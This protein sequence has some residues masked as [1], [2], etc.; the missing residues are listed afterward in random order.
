MRA[1]LNEKQD[2]ADC[3]NPD[4][5][6]Y[7]WKAL[8]PHFSD[9][10]PDEVDCNKCRAYQKT[11]LNLENGAINR[12]LRTLRASLAW[13]LGI[14]ENPGVF[15]FLQED[16]P[17]DRFLSKDEFKRLLDRAHSP[18]LKLILHLAIATAARKGALLELTW[19]QIR[20]DQ[21]ATFLGKNPM[22]KNALPFQ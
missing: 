18:H 19:I 7:A 10:L 9:L 1:Y 3:L 8:D 6:C 15:A 16:A 4:R 11:R 12:E 17:R 14:K 13:Y 22:G 21:N 20:W 5:L 2:D